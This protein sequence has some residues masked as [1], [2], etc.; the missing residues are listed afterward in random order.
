MQPNE[1]TVAVLD[2]AGPAARTR[3]EELRMML[4]DE[5]V[6]GMRAP[7]TPLDEASIARQ[8]EVS[9]TPVREAIRE[10]A[11]SGLVEIRPHRA[12]IVA[13]PAPRELIGMFESMAELEASCA[14]FAATRMTQAERTALDAIHE[15]LRLLMHSGD[16]PRYQEHNQIFHSAI[17][18]GAHNSY[19]A[20]LTVST[21][22]RLAPF[23]RAQF[24]NIGRLAKSH[25]E[26]DRVVLAIQRGDGATAA[27]FMRAH[28][29]TVCH[30]YETYLRSQQLA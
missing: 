21:R 4:A 15:E 20:G 12:A 19:L 9:R 27:A 13:Q 22:K 17:Y 29:M 1:F 30:E 7:G 10:L 3:T 26:H 6:G 8:F 16:I 25:E 11:S 24:R 18:G 14:A 2:R 5:I 23:R 28:V